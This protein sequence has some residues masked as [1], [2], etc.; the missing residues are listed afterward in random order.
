MASSSR[1][2]LEFGD[3]AVFDRNRTP[4]HKDMLLSEMSFYTVINASSL[5]GW[6]VLG[7]AA[8]ALRGWTPSESWHGL[9]LIGVVL[10]SM[11]VGS[12]ITT[13]FRSWKVSALAYLGL[14]AAPL[15]LLF[16][17]YVL[18]VGG[19]NMAYPLLA[20]TALTV[21]MTLIG[22]AIPAD[23]EQKSFGVMIVLLLSMYVTVLFVAVTSGTS[24][25][26]MIIM[27]VIGIVIFS[28][29]LVYNANRS[30]FVP[31]TLGNAVHIGMQNFL[32]T[33]NIVLR[34]AQIFRRVH[35]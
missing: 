23:L 33:V 20:T 25:G 8:F 32:E 2:E 9:A 31:K 34:L 7:T 35:S 18:D 22:R 15:G 28:L 11:I 29:G 14:I 10:A 17:P 13:K 16:G 19:K 27:A 21:I 30:K 26:V 4:H 5:I 6:I 24:T 3:P 12:I 1:H